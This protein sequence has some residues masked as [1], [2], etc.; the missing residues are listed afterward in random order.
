MARETE[1]GS[2]RGGKLRN[3]LVPAVAGLAG[4]AVAVAVTKRP[5][6]LLDAVPKQVAEAMPKVREALPAGPEGGFGEITDDLRGRLETVLG[7]D[8]ENDNQLAAFED[9]T[10]SRFDTSKFDQRRAERRERR[11]QRRRRAA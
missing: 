8:T 2:S 6:Q 1:T 7:K 9:Q 10:P 5:K 4:T 11:E 3:L